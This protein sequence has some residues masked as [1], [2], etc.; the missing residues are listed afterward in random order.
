M[1]ALETSYVTIDVFTNKRFKGNQLAVVDDTNTDLTSQQM[2]EIAREFNFSETI[3]ICQPQT[4]GM[5]QIRIFTPVN[6]MEFAGHPVIGGG[7]VLFRQFL[8]GASADPITQSTMNVKTNAGTVCLK[9]DSERQTVTAQVPHNV[10]LHETPAPKENIAR[11]QPSLTWNDIQDSH[12]TISIVQGVT[13]V[14]V[15]LTNQ[16]DNFTAIQPGPSPV[17]PLDDQ[18]APSFVGVMYY[19]ILNEQN[20]DGRKV[21]DL[22][23]RMIAINLEDPACGS[24]GCS[25]AAYLALQDGSASGKY[26]FFLDQGSEIGRDSNIIVDIL[27]NDCGDGIL[28][29]LL[30]GQAAP[31]TRGRLLLP[32]N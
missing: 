14:L 30:S 17:V 22:R 23:V 2:Q 32:T 27:L 24:G 29:V 28:S 15:N 13:Y 5:P 8:T 12:P 11:T 16:P 10:H 3:F 18:W 25:L 20:E 6:E 7:H 31:V 26:R 4:D 9:Y 1:S 21:F 19:R